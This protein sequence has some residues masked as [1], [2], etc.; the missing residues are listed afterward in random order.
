MKHRSKSERI[1]QA[2]IYLFM[3]VVVLIT[4]CP[5]WYIFAAS[6][7]SAGIPICLFLPFQKYFVEGITAGSVK[8]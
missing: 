1:F 3:A 2:G 5:L 6:L 8:G 7:V 4:I